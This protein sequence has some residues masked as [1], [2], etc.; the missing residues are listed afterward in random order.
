VLCLVA[1]DSVLNLTAEVS[2]EALDRP[3]SGITKS[4]NSVTFDLE[5]K[6]LKHI[7]LSEISIAL[8]QTS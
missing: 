7:N 2:D 6:F 3:S 4:A 1:I 8:L 5:R